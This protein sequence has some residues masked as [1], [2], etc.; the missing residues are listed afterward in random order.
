[1]PPT[2]PFGMSTASRRVTSPATSSFDT[3]S[4]LQSLGTPDAAINKSTDSMLG[5]QSPQPSSTPVKERPADNG[6]PNSGGAGAND[7][8]EQLDAAEQR[9]WGEVKEIIA[10]SFG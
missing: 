7:F 8:E 5:D 9:L 2:S 6:S 1:M 3:K 10:T 4:L